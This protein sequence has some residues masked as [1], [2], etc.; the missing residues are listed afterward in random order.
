[1]VVSCSLAM[2]L[3]AVLADPHPR[4]PTM[5]TSVTKEDEVGVVYESEN[6][7]EDHQITADNPDAKW[8]NYTGDVTQYCDCLLILH[9]ND[10]INLALTEK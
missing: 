9:N 2:M 5:W 6:F 4:L 8:T 1:M 3:S 10:F 7:V